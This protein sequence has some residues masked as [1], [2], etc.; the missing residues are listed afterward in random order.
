MD[1]QT[2]VVFVL[3]AALAYPLALTQ[4]QS[5]PTLNRK[6]HLRDSPNPNR[7]KDTRVQKHKTASRNS[8][9]AFAKELR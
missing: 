5:C 4:T 7:G 3:I 8:G 6:G 9:V 1:F 2:S